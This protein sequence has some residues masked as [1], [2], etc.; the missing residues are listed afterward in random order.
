M[1]RLRELE[2]IAILSFRDDVPSSRKPRAPLTDAEKKEIRQLYSDGVDAKELAKRF[3]IA[4]SKVGHL[5]R[6]QKAIR[7]AERE[8]AQGEI[9]SASDLLATPESDM[10][11]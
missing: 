9:G 10:P 2:K 1:K 3:H 4:A 5:C 8:K 6:E 7:N 11:F